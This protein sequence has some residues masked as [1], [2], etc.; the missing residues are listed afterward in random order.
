MSTSAGT[1]K[2]SEPAIYKATLDVIRHYLGG[3]RG[4]MLLIAATLGAGLVLNSN[5]L[6]AVGIAPLLLAL[7]PCAAICALGICMHKIGNQSGRCQ[8]HPGAQGGT[9]PPS[10]T[11]TPAVEVC[12]KTLTAAVEP[13]ISN[14]TNERS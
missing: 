2:R 9:G 11:T 4:L 6:V 3:R 14:A 7:A 8:E 12:D 13:G 1:T 10:S 5:W